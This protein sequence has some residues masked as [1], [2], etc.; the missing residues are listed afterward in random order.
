MDR[1][2]DVERLFSWIKTPDLHYREFAAEREV[3]DAVATWP[4]PRDAVT[5]PSHPG[6]PHEPETHYEPGA[7][8]EHDPHYERE[9]RYEGEDQPSYDPG[10]PEIEPRRAGRMPL[11]ERLSSLFGHREPPPEP[12][13]ARP[14]APPPPM[15]EEVAGEGQWAPESPQPAPVFA[16]LQPAPSADPN[17]APPAESA[18]NEY[19]GFEE[20]AAAPPAAEPAHADEKRS[21]DA[22]FSRVAH[23]AP[24]PRDD[25]K[26]TSAAP[27]LGP[28]FRR[29]R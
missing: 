6:E 24:A 17:P 11:G 7:Q 5:E 3:A 1:D 9:A 27:G 19:R 28:V 10:A 20:P 2:D 8:Y 12:P 25:R 21:L 14:Q 16:R 22:I 23:P 15:P 4:A 13:V 18:E 26:R 29:L